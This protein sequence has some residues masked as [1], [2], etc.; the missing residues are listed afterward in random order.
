MCFCSIISLL[1]WNKHGFSSASNNFPGSHIPDMVIGCYSLLAFTSQFL[2]KSQLFKVL[3]LCLTRLLLINTQLQ[4]LF[5]KVHLCCVLTV[6][7]TVLQFLLLFF[8][9]SVLNSYNSLLNMMPCRVADYV[10][11]RQRSIMILYTRW[12]ET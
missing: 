8:R 1:G 12:V 7:T 10:F 2:S 3:V 11:F 9:F 6:G 4:I 5:S